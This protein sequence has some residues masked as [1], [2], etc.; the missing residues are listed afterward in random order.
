MFNP[1]LEFLHLDEPA[2]IGYT[3]KVHWLVC[4]GNHDGL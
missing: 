4:N 2:A 1:T 3:F